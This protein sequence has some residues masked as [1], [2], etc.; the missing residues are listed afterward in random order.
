MYEDNSLITVEAIGKE[1]GNYKLYGVKEINIYS[2]DSLIKTL[3]MQEAIEKDGISMV[4]KDYTMCPE[5]IADECLIKTVDINFDGYLDLQVFAW[6]T[7]D[8][9]YYYYYCWNAEESG[10]DYAFCLNDPEIDAENQLL[11]TYNLVS[12]YEMYHYKYY[13]VNEDNTLELIKTVEEP[14]VDEGY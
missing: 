7:K 2:A 5:S 12:R 11:I 9:S 10:F 13:K 14:V 8:T 3:I 4:E 1:L 6:D